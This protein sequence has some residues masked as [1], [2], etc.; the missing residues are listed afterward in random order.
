VKIRSV[1]EFED[2]VYSEFSW[3]RKE[4]TNLRSIALSARSSTRE[5]LFRSTIPIVYA[6]WEGFVKRTAIAKMNYLAN[7]GYKYKELVPSFHAYA[8]LAEYDGQIPTKR[9]DTIDRLMCGDIDLNKSIS[10]DIDKYIDT[11]WNLNSEVLKEIAFKINI[12]YADF[13]LKENL[14]DEKFL[15]LRNKIVH[16]DRAVVSEDDFEEVYHEATE[17][18]NSF[19]NNLLNSVHTKSYLLNP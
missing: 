8:A 17:L 5:S 4:L 6:H 14:I 19:K 10:L 12:D 11:K 2:L 13:E 7:K 9:F 3:R 15:G 16:G 18:I 1:S